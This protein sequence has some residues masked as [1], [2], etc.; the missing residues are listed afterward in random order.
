MSE[1]GIIKVIEM[2]LALVTV[3][4]TGIISIR[5]GKLHSQINSRMTEL[6]NE[7]RKSSKAEGKVEEK[8]EEDERK[9]KN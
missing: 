1:A 7:T 3:A 2:I 4:I 6:L 8:A 5:L 9:L